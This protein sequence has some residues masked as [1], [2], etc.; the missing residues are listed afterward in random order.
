MANGPYN[1]RIVILLKHTS[2]PSDHDSIPG[3]FLLHVCRVARPSEYYQVPSV[4][5]PVQ[6]Y[7]QTRSVIEGKRGAI[8]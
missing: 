3:Y 5:Q 1:S 4:V 2:L 8:W 6:I 7:L